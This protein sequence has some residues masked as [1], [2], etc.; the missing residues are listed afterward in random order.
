MNRPLVKPSLVDALIPVVLLIA[1]LAGTVYVFGLDSFGP[2]QVALFF[3]AAVAALIG[4]KNGLSWKEVE[5]GMIDTIT[6]SLHAILILLMVGALIGSWILAGTVPSMIYYGV[7]LMSPDYFYMTCCLVCALV[8]FSIGSS[9]TVAGTL[10]IGFMGIAAALDLS[11]P[12]SAGAIISGAYF[13]DKLSPLSDTTNLAAAVTNSDLFDHIQHMLWTTIPS[14]VIALTLFFIL[15]MDSNINV[16]VDD[17][18]ILQAA[19]QQAFMVNPLMLGPLVLL[20]FMAVRRQPAL[21]TLI[22]GALAGCV[23]AVLFQWD[24][25]ITL[26][27]DPSLNSAAAIFK[28]LFSAMF[29]GFTSVSGNESMDALLSKGGM[30][31]ML[32][33]VGLVIN[34][35]AFGGAMA[36][37]GLLE[38]LVEAALSRVKSAGGLVTTTV[39]TC[40]GTNVLAADQY[41]SIVIP[42]QMFADSY[43]RRKLRL[44]NLSRTLEDSGTLT[45]V[46]IPWNTCGAY[47]SATLGVSTFYYAPYAFFN[48]CCPLIAIL[49]GFYQIKLPLTDESTQAAG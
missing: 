49:Y 23:F 26:A 14:F 22:C 4:I 20:L 34:A 44:I 27:A 35:M 7:E 36:R 43:K 45:S 25:V 38:R 21:S 9:W 13:G 5:Q 16:K 39:A 41:L 2:N 31:N 46:L 11:L 32:M 37:T 18:E 24:A 15:G 19:M 10:G 8:G 40:I 28:G 6:V 33:T 47:M 3:A 17:I 30:Q 12:I 1:M 29:L 48:L 42:G